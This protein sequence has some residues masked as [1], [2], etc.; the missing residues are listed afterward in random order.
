MSNQSTLQAAIKPLQDEL[1]AHEIY[2]SINSVEAVQHFMRFHVF[3]VWDFM[4][5][6]KRLQRDLTCTSTPWTP[7]TNRPA[8]YIINQIVL[9]EESDDF[10]TG[11]VTNAISHYELYLKAMIEV[12]T[13]PIEVTKLVSMIQR[14]LDFKEALDAHQSVFG[15][16]IPD[17]VYNFVH[18]TLRTAEKGATHEVMAAFLFGRED[19]IPKMF[20]SIIDNKIL[21]AEKSLDSFRLYLQRHIDVDGDDHGPLAFAALSEICGEDET[22]WE[23]ATAAAKNAIEMRIN[24]WTGISKVASSKPYS[25]V[26]TKVEERINKRVT[27]TANEHLK[28]IPAATQ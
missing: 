19:P 23:E 10:D 1:L 25:K 16:S 11:K 2:G 9:G 13:D 7:P 4:S 18:D 17:A 8:A 5:L 14:G 12:G 22:K 24:F 3:S 27:K 15:E 26:T 28:K 6:V 20:Q 21:S